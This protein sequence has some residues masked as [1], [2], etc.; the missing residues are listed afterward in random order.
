MGFLHNFRLC[1]VRLQIQV[2]DSLHQQRSII[3]KAVHF[4]LCCNVTAI[5]P[6]YFKHFL[7]LSVV[8]IPTK[9][10]IYSE[11]PNSES[12]Q[13]SFYTVATGK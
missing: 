13:H 2:A 11:E 12:T 5:L 9:T 4:E 6:L 8:L 7:Q 1:S 10:G 3:N